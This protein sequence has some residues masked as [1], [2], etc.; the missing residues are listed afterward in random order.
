MFDVRKMSYSLGKT[1][2]SDKWHLKKLNEATN[3]S[4]CEHDIVR[5]IKEN[6]SFYDFGPLIANLCVVCYDTL[7]FGAIRDSKKWKSTMSKFLSS[8]EEE[9]FRIISKYKTGNMKEVL[10]ASE[11][12]IQLSKSV[13]T[14]EEY[15]HAE[16]VAVMVASHSKKEKSEAINELIEI[17]SPPPKRPLY[18]AQNEMQ[19]LPTC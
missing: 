8:K 9:E 4:Y 5:E 1:K 17:V 18:Y 7:T 3:R 11:D 16:R 14:N 2:S 6:I 10:L 12:I 15:E 19:Y 13:M